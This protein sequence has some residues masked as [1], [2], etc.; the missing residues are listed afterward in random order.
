MRAQLYSRI[1]VPGPSR[2]SRSGL[3]GHHPTIRQTNFDI[4]M[5]PRDLVSTRLYS[6]RKPWI[7]RR[8]LR[9]SPPVRHWTGLRHEVMERGQT[10]HTGRRSVRFEFNSRR[11]QGIRESCRKI[12]LSA[13]FQLFRTCSS[14]P[15]PPFCD[16]PQPPFCAES[17]LIL[18]L[19][20]LFYLNLLKI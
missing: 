20:T 3:I 4:A 15:P 2:L 14:G 10:C 12:L 17:L 13:V 18:S 5:F 11:C 1:A 9:Q 7:G 19:P 8:L 16:G 6:L